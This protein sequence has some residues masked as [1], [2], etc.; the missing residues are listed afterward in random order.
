[1]Y[2]IF[3]I[4]FVLVGLAF[5]Y[6]TTL[7]VTRRNLLIKSAVFSAHFLS[8]PAALPLI[9]IHTY[10]LLRTHQPKRFA[11]LVQMKK[12]SRKNVEAREARRFKLEG[13]EIQTRGKNRLGKR[14]G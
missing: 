2:I 10:A 7:T 11:M 4:Y 9:H 12:S 5:I 14:A 1:M 13:Q 8:P 6:I 3:S